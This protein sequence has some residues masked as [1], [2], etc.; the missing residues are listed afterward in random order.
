VAVVLLALIAPP[1][2][3]ALH[4][5]HNSVH[6]SLKVSAAGVPPDA[7]FYQPGVRE[8]FAWLRDDPRP[9][10]V[11]APTYLGVAVPGETG[12]RTFVGNSY[13]S[14][15]LVTYF[16]RD[17]AARSLFSGPITRD[18]ARGVVRDSGARF[19]LA[20]CPTRTSLPREL[21]GMVAETHRFKCTRVL[22]LTDAASR[23]R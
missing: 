8:A 11:L 3:H 19:V 22:V 21:S 17:G 9:G 5:A 20:D 6:Y 12:R 18:V 13:W 4:E 1:A 15:S 14:G 2:V 16:L 10:S 23:R 7:R